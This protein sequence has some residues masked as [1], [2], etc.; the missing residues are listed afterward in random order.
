MKELRR[1]RIVTTEKPPV[2]HIIH[3]HIHT[4]EEETE[5]SVWL[6]AWVAVAGAESTMDKEVCDSWA[7]HCVASY[8]ERYED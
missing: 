2:T 6:K 7:D 1:G 8:R 4:V 5:A 3:N